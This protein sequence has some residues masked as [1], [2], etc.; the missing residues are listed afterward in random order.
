MKPA[1]RMQKLLSLSAILLLFSNGVIAQT[2]AQLIYVS[3]DQMLINAQTHVATYFNQVKAHQGQRTLAA[4]KLVI[5][6]GKSSSVQQMT[7]YGNPAISTYMPPDKKHKESIGK[8]QQ[9]VYIPNQNLVRYQHDA[10]LEQDGNIFKGQIINYNT[11]TQTASSPSTPLHPT[12]ITIPAYDNDKHT[13]P[14]ST[15]SR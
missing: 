3:S 12:V 10:S 2:P 14:T 9:I 15:E 13:P 4:N 1:N 8:A 5:E 11:L 6:Q 7:A